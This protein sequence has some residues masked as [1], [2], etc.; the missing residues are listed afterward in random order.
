MVQEISV[1]IPTDWAGI[2]LK[3]YLDLQ[4]ELKNYEEDEEA[5]TAIMLWKVC[6][7]PADMIK[8]ID[9]ES[10]NDIRNTLGAFISNVEL[11]LK[12]F[13]T[14]N[15]VEYGFEPNLSKMPYGA[16]ADITK[17]S[18]IQIDEN[19]TKIMNILYRPIERKNGGMYTIKPYTGTGDDTI[20]NEVGM[21]VHF[22]ALFFLLNLSTDLLNYT[23]KY[24][25]EKEANPNIKSILEKSGELMQ[26]SLSLPMETSKRLMQL[27]KSH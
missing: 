17:F 13:V 2:S 3:T 15:G 20:F 23:L 27:L 24:S 12:Q 26:Q 1:K 14:I 9:M 4:A 5:M 22:G 18:T 7:I 11:P 6:N 8:T 21:D 16:Y 25:M 10:Y 19:W